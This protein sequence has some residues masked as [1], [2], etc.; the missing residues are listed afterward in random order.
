MEAVC[1]KTLCVEAT[2]FTIESILKVTSCLR[3][4][5]SKIISKTLHYLPDRNIYSIKYYV[6]SN[7]ARI[8]PT[9]E[10]EESLHAMSDIYGQTPPRTRLSRKKR[11]MKQKYSGRYVIN[12]NCKIDL[13]E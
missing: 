1:A 8:S 13:R 12:Q 4:N 7:K 2:T 6:C 3:E 10:F 9:N 5:P 11:H